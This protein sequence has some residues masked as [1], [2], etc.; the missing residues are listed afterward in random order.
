[1]NTV[2]NFMMQSFFNLGPSRDK[3]NAAHG[4]EDAPNVFTIMT[5]PVAPQAI[6]TFTDSLMGVA[7]RI[8]LGFVVGALIFGTIIGIATDCPFRTLEPGNFDFIRE[9]LFQGLQVLLPLRLRLDSFRRTGSYRRHSSCF[10][11]S[12]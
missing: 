5:P 2:S 6:I 1:M 10:A 12:T 3:R 11:R 8:F 7:N 9:F 4:T